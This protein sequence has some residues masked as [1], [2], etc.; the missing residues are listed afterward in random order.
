MDYKRDRAI[1]KLKEAGLLPNSLENLTSIQQKIV[2]DV[3]GFKDSRCISYVNIINEYIDHTNVKCKQKYVCKLI[4]ERKNNNRNKVNG[5]MVNVNPEDIVIVDR[6]P[7]FNTKLIYK[8]NPKSLF[9][10][11]HIS[12]DRIDNSKGYVKGNVM[13]VSRLANAMKSSSTIN[14]L[15][16]FCTNVIKN[17]YKP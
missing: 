3:M 5:I 10:K 15:R 11:Y 8:K 9:D 13:I 7:Y 2:D 1:F 6:C 16:T 12:V 17:I 14:E 4:K